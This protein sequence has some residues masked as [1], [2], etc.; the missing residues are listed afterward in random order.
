MLSNTMPTGS[1]GE[2]MQS[3]VRMLF[4]FAL[5]SEESNQ[6]DFTYTRGTRLDN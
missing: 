3:K 1:G 4:F 2:S 6:F 5:Q